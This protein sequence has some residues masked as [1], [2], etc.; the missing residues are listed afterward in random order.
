MSPQYASRA[1]S[2]PLPIAL[3]AL[4]LRLGAIAY[5]H[6]YQFSADGD[7]LAFGYEFGRVARSIAMGGGFSSP[8]YVP[9]GPTALL[10]PVYAYLLAGVFKIFGVYS[11]ASAVGILSL[12]SVFSAL[13]CVTI[14]FIGQKTFGPTVGTWAAW[15][16]AVYPDSVF[17]TVKWVWETTLSALL[18]SL[19]L[20]AA[21]HLERPAPIRAWLG[22]GLLWGL[23][24]L[25]NPA[26]LS[27]LPF[28]LGWIWYRQRQEG[29]RCGRQIGVAALV[30]VLSLTPWLV[31]N[32]L[33]FG[34][35]IF[36]RDGFWLELLVGVH[37]QDTDWALPSHPTH[38][39]GK[40]ELQ[41]LTQIGEMAYMA[42]KRHQALDLIARH[43]GLFALSTLQRACNHWV[44]Y[45]DLRAIF[46]F[47]GG[48]LLVRSL[49]GRVT[50]YVLLSVLAF[51]GLLLAIRVRAREAVPLGGCLAFF[52]LVYYVTH[53]DLRFR[54]PIEPV[55]VVLAAYFV[56]TLLGRCRATAHPPQEGCGEQG[57]NIFKRKGFAP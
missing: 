55:M 9:T 30:C 53:A 32:Y 16:W 10:P 57:F 7:Y 31:R 19:V 15:G 44:A 23:A 18:L 36:I 11:V 27:L 51:L 12:N 35:F 52:P 4:A 17:W 40:S 56:V 26:I 6:T 14:F 22:F 43:P 47:R 20:L 28:S 41:R 37:E 8:Y 54:Q 42:E 45:R 2:S 5:F 39:K 34:Q 33:T 48:L 25:T 50:A 24:A 38:P 1:L 13:T 3:A 49:V 46:A 21:L 29:V